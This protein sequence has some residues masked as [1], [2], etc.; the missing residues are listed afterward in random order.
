MLRKFKAQIVP[1]TA[2]RALATLVTECD[3]TGWP[4]QWASLR[5]GARDVLHTVRDETD[6]MLQI[7][8]RIDAG[9]GV[10][11]LFADE[12]PKPLEDAGIVTVAI[13]FDLST[14]L[15]DDEHG[16]DALRAFVALI[17]RVGQSSHYAIALR[18]GTR[19]A[20]YADVLAEL[21]RQAHERGVLLE[22]REPVR[23]SARRVDSDDPT[24][25]AW[26]IPGERIDPRDVFGDG[27]GA[28]DPRAALDD[29]DDEERSF[30]DEAGLGW[31]VRLRALEEAWRTVAFAAHPDRRPDDPDASRRFVLL[32]S[33]YERLRER[34]V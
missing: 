8:S 7:I 6:A 1:T 34:A 3:S 9:R 33:G 22:A 5:E 2:L 10:L 20:V 15:S 14:L 27:S 12:Q 28:M 31:P 19:D 32:K 29:L 25:S 4:D 24:Q 21:A 30:L 26:K 16:P 17:E 23:P 13:D 18:M 11:V